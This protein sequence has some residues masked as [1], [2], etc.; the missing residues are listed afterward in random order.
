MMVSFLFEKS[1]TRHLHH[2]TKG[3]RLISHKIGL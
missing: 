2:R 1:E 3:K